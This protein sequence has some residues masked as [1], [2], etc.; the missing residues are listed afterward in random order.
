MRSHNVTEK[1]KYAGVD[2]T[3]L[4]R[5][6]VVNEFNNEDNTYYKPSSHGGKPVIAIDDTRVVFFAYILGGWK[7]TVITTLPDDTFYEVTYDVAKDVTYVDTYVKRRNV[8]I[9]NN[10]GGRKVVEL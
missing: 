5:T 4:A 7:S 3:I 8:V 10:G 2:P 9:T 6:A 1:V